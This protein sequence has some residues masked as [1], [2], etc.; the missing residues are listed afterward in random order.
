MQISS[1]KN[2]H[3]ANFMEKLSTYKR[4][5]ERICT[6]DSLQICPVHE[7]KVNLWIN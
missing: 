2:H 3:L 1:H 4:P 7:N 6:F 5:N